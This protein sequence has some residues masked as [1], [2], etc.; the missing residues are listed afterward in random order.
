MRLQLSSSWVFTL[1]PF[2]RW[3]RPLANLL[4][5]LSLIW[6]VGVFYFAALF[7]EWE[8]VL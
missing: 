6:I 1:P 3:K 4:G 5:W 7:L 2:R 8:G